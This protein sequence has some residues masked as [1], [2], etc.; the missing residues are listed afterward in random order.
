MRATL[1]SAVDGT[2]LHRHWKPMARPLT[3][4]LA[5][6]SRWRA[7]TSEAAPAADA[8][9]AIV[10]VAVTMQPVAGGTPEAAPAADAAAAV[11][12]VDFS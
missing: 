2:D 6:L 9:V 11:V 8:A 4:A 1:P 10:V 12:V 7:K 5:R 3:S